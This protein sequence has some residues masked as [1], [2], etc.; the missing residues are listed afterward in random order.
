MNQRELS[1]IIPSY[2]KKERL[3]KTIKILL[4]HF[5][6]A[7]IIVINDGSQDKT[8]E[9]KDIF[10][11]Q[12]VYLENEKNQGKGFSLKKGFKKANGQYLIFTD[13]DLP[14]GVESIEDALQEFK[15]GAEVVIGERHDFYNDKL[16]KKLLRPFLYLFLK[17]LFGFYYSDTQ[18]GLKGFK[19]EAAQTIFSLTFTNQFAIDVEILYLSR[20]LGYSVKAILIKQ[21]NFGFSTFNFRSII[22]MFFDLFKI[23]FHHYDYEKA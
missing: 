18:A 1:I 4:E 16:L 20:K 3:Q 19:R 13:D 6:E 15:K 23:R 12:I 21:Q 14:Y 5:P 7:E 11:N 8:K 9:V 22:K 10:G 2:Q 17:I